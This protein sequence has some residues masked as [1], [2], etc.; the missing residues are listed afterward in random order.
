M[1]A[2]SKLSNDNVE[3][4]LPEPADIQADNGARH[5]HKSLESAPLLNESGD[6]GGSNVYTEFEKALT[7]RIVEASNFVIKFD[8]EVA[9]QV[10]HFLEFLYIPGWKPPKDII[11]LARLYA[12]GE[13]F[14][15][16]R[17]QKVILDQ[18]GAF[19]KEWAP[20]HIR[21]GDICALLEIACNDIME[22]PYL[23]DDPI[24]KYVFWLAAARLS[25]LHKSNDFQWLLC[26]N[27]E[28][29]KELC[30]MPS[31]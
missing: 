21:I 28:L 13:R 8:D 2:H 11:L 23:N 14:S 26:D 30:L 22:H 7:V 9:K 3:S 20:R 31:Y 10:M 17:F 5:L 19:L 6:E 18:F 15:A 29:A 24:R 12:M 1:N 16:A 25:E 27:D 4:L